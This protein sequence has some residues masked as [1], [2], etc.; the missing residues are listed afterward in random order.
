[1]ATTVTNIMSV[2]YSLLR[3]AIAPSWTLWEMLRIFSLPELSFLSRLTSTMTTNR[4][5]A[6][7]MGPRAQTIQSMDSPLLTELPRPCRYPRLAVERV[8][9]I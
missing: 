9:G 2:L 5:T 3:K 6:A 7:V 8:A 4:A 1:M